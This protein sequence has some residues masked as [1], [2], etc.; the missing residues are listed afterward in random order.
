MGLGFESRQIL[1]PKFWV[2]LCI[3]NPIS[4]CD[5]TFQWSLFPEAYR[6]NLIHPIRAQTCLVSKAL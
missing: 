6:T 2:S 3:K 1:D 4:H 5:F